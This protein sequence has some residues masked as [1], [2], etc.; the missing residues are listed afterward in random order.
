MISDI[1]VSFSLL[2]YLSFGGKMLVLHVM[3]AQAGSDS[4]IVI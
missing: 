1:D 3:L 4:S 2:V